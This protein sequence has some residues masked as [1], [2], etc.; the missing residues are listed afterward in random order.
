MRLVF[1]VLIS[2]M[3]GSAF[4]LALTSAK[5]DPY[6]WCA[7]MSAGEDGGMD[8]CYFMTLEQCRATI[9][10]IGGFC[11]ANLWYDGRPEGATPRVQPAKK[12]T[13]PRN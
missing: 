13:Q 9:S 5:A 10:G 4:T 11:R 7:I 8:N 12:K 3:A 6:K 2:L 1:A